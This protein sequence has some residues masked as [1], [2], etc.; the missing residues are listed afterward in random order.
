MGENCEK[1]PSRAKYMTDILNLRSLGSERPNKSICKHPCNQMCSGL[2]FL[3]NEVPCF[4]G[5]K[6][7][8]HELEHQANE[9]GFDF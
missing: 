2:S 1:K 6:S 7:T 5:S 8:F 3:T 9:R 4:P